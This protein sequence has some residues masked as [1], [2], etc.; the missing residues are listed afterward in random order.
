MIQRIQSVYLLLAAV[1]L[2][3][4]LCLPA[5]YFVSNEGI[6]SGTFK[7]LGVTLTDGTSLSTWGVFVLSLLSA[8]I[9]V[10]TI[11]LYRNR[12]LQ[13]RMSIFSIVVIVGYYVAFIVFVPAL[14]ERLLDTTFQTGW[15]LC[16]PFISVILT[17][18]AFR[19]IRH[20]EELVKATDR[21]R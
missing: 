10:C 18:L 3:I 4:S 8:L 6:I 9:Q 7:P 20:D 11:F 15:A 14:K 1:A 17:W 16:L 21:L 5:G 13:M 2:V 12:T 19:A